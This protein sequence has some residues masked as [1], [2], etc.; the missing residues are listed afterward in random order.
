MQKHTPNNTILQLVNEHYPEYSDKAI[1]LMT[2]GGGL[3]VAW[4][5]NDI[6][7][8]DS[9]NFQ[10]QLIHGRYLLV[11]PINFQQKALK[12]EQQHK[13]SAY[14]EAQLKREQECYDKSVAA[15]RTFQW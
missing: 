5:Y 2:N 8:G 11:S 14:K 9:N 15:Q 4:D 12:I 3:I 1:Y 7:V 10:P 6:S 13:K